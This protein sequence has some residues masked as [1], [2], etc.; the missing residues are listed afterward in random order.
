MIT[1]QDPPDPAETLEPVSG[2][3]E[4]CGAGRTGQRMARGISSDD[5]AAIAS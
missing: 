2:F 1:K 4:R 5:I 3:I